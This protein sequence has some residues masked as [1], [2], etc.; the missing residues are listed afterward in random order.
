MINT[1]GRRPFCAGRRGVPEG[2]PSV[3]DIVNSVSSWIRKKRKRLRKSRR[4]ACLRRM[5]PVSCALLEMMHGTTPGEWRHDC[6]CSRHEPTGTVL[7][8]A[9]P[10]G[11]NYLNC[12]ARDI[13]P[14]DRPLLWREFQRIVARG[15]EEEARRRILKRAREILDDEED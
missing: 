2:G 15:D 6:Y 10:G 11:F 4:K 3:L 8:T 1:M 5:S 12:G 9:S 7:Y 13:P 14:R